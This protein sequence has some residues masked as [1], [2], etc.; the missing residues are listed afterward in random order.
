MRADVSLLTAFLLLAS[1]VSARIAPPA[2][3]AATLEKLEAQARAT[4]DDADVLRRLAAEQAAAGN[5]DLALAT[6]ERA[7][8]L[9]PDDLDIRLA[10][11]RILT[12]SGRRD[13][14]RAEA[15]TVAAR[16]PRYPELAE[17]RAALTGPVARQRPG[18]AASVGLASVKLAG[19]DQV[20]T[21]LTGTGFAPVSARAIAS[22]TIETEARRR[23][24]TRLTAR[25]DG[26]LAAGE[27][28]AEV[29]VTPDAD[30][31][32]RSSIAG[33]IVHPVGSG[34]DGS[35]NLRHARYADVSVTVVEPG[36]RLRLAGDRLILSAKW[37]NLFRSD[38]DHRS[39]AAVR[40]DWNIEGDHILFAGGA[41][42]PDTEAGITRQ[43]RAVYAGAILPA[44]DR[45]S[46]RL[47]GDYE[48]RAATYTRRGA[49]LGLVWRL[50][51]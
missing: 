18:V 13:D 8:M 11:A 47:T 46:L 26:R 31:R 16:D 48:H 35:F 23:T 50:G 21:T 27:A 7:R 30:F 15:D 28:Y 12:W 37:I 40:G 44:S 45:L 4:P 6:I 10:R 19:D 41:T 42:Y 14:A 2:T 33:G 39:G 29:A 49:T 38:D 9:A 36:V 22:V 34:L 43:V 5:L 51:R 20:W 1:P 25:L 24:D 32:E 3:P 17:V